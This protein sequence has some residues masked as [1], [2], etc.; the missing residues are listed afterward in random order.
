M[1]ARGYYDPKTEEED[2]HARYTSTN[3]NVTEVSPFIS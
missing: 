3:K 2:H 1:R